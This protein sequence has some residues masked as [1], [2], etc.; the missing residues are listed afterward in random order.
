[1]LPWKVNPI[2][3]EAG[4]VFQL[5]EIH[6]INQSLYQLT[7]KFVNTWWKIWI[8]SIP[9][10]NLSWKKKKMSGVS[11]SL[12]TFLLGIYTL[13]VLV[14]LSGNETQGNWEV[15]QLAL[16]K[17]CA[18]KCS[19]PCLFMRKIIIISWFHHF[20]EQGNFVHPRAW[21]CIY[22]KSGDLTVWYL[23]SLHN[24]FVSIDPR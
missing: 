5:Q 21:F 15:V 20:T 2:A 23:K 6:I 12:P 1:M 16:L 3:S 13:S 18:S 14:P 19:F 9:V 22:I 10:P 4:Y 17:V 11:G 7:I 8:I 24:I